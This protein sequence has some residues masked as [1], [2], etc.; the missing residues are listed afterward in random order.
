M[1]HLRRLPGYS[2][3]LVIS[4]A[5]TGLADDAQRLTEHCL[6]KRGPINGAMIRSGGQQLAVYGWDDG[7]VD[8]LLLTHGRRDVI[9][10][11]AT[12]AQKASIIAPMREKYSLE[13]GPDFWA[14]F[15][16]TRYHDYAQQ[17]TKIPNEV[18]QV[19][20]WVAEGDSISWNGLTFEVLETPGYTR[21]SATYVVQLD[22]KR[23]GFSGDL[24]YGDGKILDLYS[25][26]DAIPNAQVRGYHGYGARLADL[27]SSLDKIVDAKLDVIVPARGPVIRQPTE[28]ALRL[29]TRA[30]NVYRNYL[31]T[32]AL[33]W[34]FKEDRMRLC[35]ERVLGQDADIT[36]MPYAHHEQTPEWIFEESTSR[37]LISDS[38]QG[39]LLDC[40]NQRVIDAVKKLID[41][42]VIAK[43]DGIF[44]THYHD[45]HTDKV[46][47]A[48]EEFD[49]PVY[50][51]AQYAD[52]LERPEAYHLPAMT[53]NPIRPIRRVKSG[54]SMT[55]NEFELTFHFFPGQTYYHGALFVQKPNERPVFFVGDAFAPSGIDDY[56]VLNRNLLHDDD[57]YLLCLDK[58]RSAGE[59]WLI[60]EHIKYVFTFSRE[61]LE[62]LETQY[63]ARAAMLREMFPWDDPNYGVDEQWAVLYPRGAHAKRGET[64]ELELRITNHSPV[65]RQFQVTPHLPPGLTLVACGDAVKLAPRDGGSVKLKVHVDGDGGASRVV[66]A[67]IISDGMQFYRWADALIT[68]EP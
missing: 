27:V 21:G 46:Q 37:L 8:Q 44:V 60:N 49:C 39:F 64:I 47:A 14:R 23:I 5:A 59:C 43:V 18:I 11:A 32:S 25:F 2:L 45:D 50:A 36:L 48:A 54:Q 3:L 15:P 58:V 16:E 12:A 24:I 40:G 68:V 62:Y 13:N 52:V 30:Q 42:D 65:A 57:G 29:K 61:E 10:R 9:W 1:N 28:S 63:R 6:V 38:G 22:G 34:Y 17:S 35:G 7:A 4:L 19:S 55:W 53:A 26:Q 41:Q 33:H 67:D 31:S 51:T 66:T 20:R 56:C